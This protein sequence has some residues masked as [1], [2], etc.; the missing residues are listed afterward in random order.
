LIAKPC[1]VRG[2]INKLNLIKVKNAC[3]AT[4]LLRGET[5]KLNGRRKYLQTTYP[6]KG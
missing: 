5:N 1:C 4:D 6:T 2:K 3:S